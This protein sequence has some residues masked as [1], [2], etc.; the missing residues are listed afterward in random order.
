MHVSAL[1]DAR[2]E[3]TCDLDLPFYPGGQV[4]NTQGR[5]GLESIVVLTAKGREKIQADCLA[6]SGGWKP[7]VHLTCHMNGRPTWQDDIAAF[8]PTPGSIPGLEAAGAASG[9]ME[10]RA[11]LQNGVEVA[12]RALADLGLSAPDMDVP[13]ASD[14]PYDVT[15]LWAV[16]GKGRAWLDFQNDVSV[17]DIK[18]SEQ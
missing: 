13:D 15:P 14:S 2:A 4:I 17:K 3:A 6:V 10:T 1:I 16:P 7:T 11:C 5:K 9:V 18:Q 8:V 12:T